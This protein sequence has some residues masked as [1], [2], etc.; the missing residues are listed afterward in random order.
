[1]PTMNIF[2]RAGKKRQRARAAQA[3]DWPEYDYLRAEV[4]KRLV[5]RLEDIMREFPEA[6]ELGAY[7]PHIAKE[8]GAVQ[9]LSGSK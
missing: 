3:P 2:D 1:M 4:A 9:G 5:D 6:L 7:G 8:I